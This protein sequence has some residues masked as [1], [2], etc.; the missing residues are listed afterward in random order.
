LARSPVAPKI[1]SASI[2]SVAIRFSCSSVSDDGAGFGF[3]GPVRL[4]SAGR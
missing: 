3:A 2:C 1:T 4:S